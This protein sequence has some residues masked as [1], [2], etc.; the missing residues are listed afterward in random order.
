MRVRAKQMLTVFHKA[1]DGVPAYKDFLKKN[2]IDP[3]KIKTLRDFQLVPLMSKQNY[4][5]RYELEKLC[6]GETLCQPLVFTST[7]GSTGEPF[8][9]PRNF[10]IDY[11]SSIYH[12]SFFHSAEIDS[13]KSTLV[14]VCFGMGIWIGGLITYQAFRLIAERGY[15]LTLLTPGIN[16]KEIFE[17][18]KNLSKKFDQIIICG[19]PPF[20]KDII[21]EASKNAVNWRNF[22]NLKLVFAAETFSE[23]FRDYIIR[24]TGIKKLYCDTMNIYGSADM[25]TMASETPVSILVRRIALKNK[26]VYKKLF[27]EAT[28]LPTLVQ[29]IP[30]FINFEIVGK[31]IYCTGDNAIPLI[32]YEIGDNG[33]VFDFNFMEQVF[34]ENGIDFNKEACD[35]GID[36]TIIKLP[37]VY[38]YERT[39]LSTKLYGAIIYPEHVREALQDARFETFLTSKFT[40]LTKYDRRQNQFLEINIELK[41]NIKPIKSLGKLCCDNII[42]N[43]LRKNAEYH[44]NYTSLS[45]EVTP[46]IIFWPHEHILHFK[47]GIK[48]KWVKTV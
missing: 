38:I 22:K 32:R 12:E 10:F 17:A 48:Q 6:Y 45:K 36:G 4:L 3:A 21:D 41:P 19:Y 27:T 18:L 26:K 13:H 25:G 7:S 1:A 28:R 23:K 24:E 16:K 40:M 39:D 5:R 11:Q 43:L 33:G 44:N 47:P 42:K 15:P 29:F 34:I 2:K 46:H 9:F 8:Y 31:N 20:V 14:L 30:Q 37:F 35:A